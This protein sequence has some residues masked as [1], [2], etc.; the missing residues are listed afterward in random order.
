MPHGR[1]GIMRLGTGA[2]VLP[3]KAAGSL[4]FFLFCSLLFPPLSPLLL[5]FLVS[6]T[7]LFA[8]VTA[9]Q[10]PVPVRCSRFQ[11][12]AAACLHIKGLSGCL[13]LCFMEGE[14]G[15]QDVGCGGAG[16]RGDGGTDEE[17]EKTEQEGLFSDR[18]VNRE[19]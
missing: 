8:M 18:S 17:R 4:L 1:G 14:N 3:G 13:S 15:E 9:E 6:F 16:G 2:S 19:R 5:S 7:L 10:S 12:V 11:S